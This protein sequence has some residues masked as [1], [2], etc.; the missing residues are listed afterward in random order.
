MPK[1]IRLPPP[2]EHWRRKALEGME[3]DSYLTKESV[4]ALFKEISAAKGEIN[5]EKRRNKNKDPI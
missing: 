3:L 4:K 5:K 2:N 1:K